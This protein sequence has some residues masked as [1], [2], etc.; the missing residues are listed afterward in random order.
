MI[1]WSS[2]C[3]KYGVRRQ[4]V[5]AILSVVGAVLFLTGSAFHL[6]FVQGLGIGMFIVTGV[7]F[8]SMKTA[9]RRK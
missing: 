2:I 1:V 6:S 3:A 9:D 7:S 5:I 8:A 4:Q